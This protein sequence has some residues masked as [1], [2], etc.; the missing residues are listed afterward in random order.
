M[1][2]STV[3][4]VYVRLHV[5]SRARSTLLPNTARGIDWHRTVAG[6]AIL[7]IDGN[8][9]LASQD[10]LTCECEEE[11]ELRRTTYGPSWLL[12]RF[13]RL[14]AVRR[15]D[16]GEWLQAS[17][18]PF[19]RSSCLAEVRVVIELNLSGCTGRGSQRWNNILVDERCLQGQRVK[20]LPGIHSNAFERR[21]EGG[22]SSHLSHFPD[23]DLRYLPI[24][25]VGTISTTRL[26]WR[27]AGSLGTSK[28]SYI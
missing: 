8:V 12:H 11:N 6:I 9:E 17:I 24:W 5:A 3:Y 1:P 10:E 25:L 18:N 15:R 28:D 4:L 20:V 2:S 14:L 26:I 21:A 7:I 13:Q 23:A 22:N 19:S 16:V 27:G